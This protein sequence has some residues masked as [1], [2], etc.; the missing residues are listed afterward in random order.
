[1]AK[2]EY[3]SKVHAHQH[4]SVPRHASVSTPRG[5]F[6]EDFC[7][8][9]P[10]FSPHGESQKRGRRKICEGNEDQG[11]DFALSALLLLLLEFLVDRFSF[12]EE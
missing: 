2:E 11:D 4:A 7:C 1:M 8:T 3:R 5:G 6:S 10:P 9:L 12:C